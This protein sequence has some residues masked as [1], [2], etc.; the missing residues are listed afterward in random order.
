MFIDSLHMFFQTSFEYLTLYN[1]LSSRFR[2]GGSYGSEPHHAFCGN[3]Q[4]LER[5]LNYT[6]VQGF[7]AKPII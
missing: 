1:K 2:E 7:S 5:E 6:N 4:N 3:T